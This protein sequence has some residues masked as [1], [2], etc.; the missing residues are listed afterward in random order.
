MEDIKKQYKEAIEYF[1][2]K[3][4]FIS[5]VILITILSFGF[6]ITNSSVGMDDVSFDRYY[7]D[8]EMLA[9]GRW[10]SY[11]VYQILN[12]TDFVPFWI[13]FIA[14]TIIMSVAVVW[15]IFLKKNLGDK[16][17]I[18]SYIIFASVFISFPIINEI[19]IYQNCN[20]AVMLGS[21]LASIGIMLLYENFNNIHKKRIY[22]YCMLILTLGI[23]MYEACA[24]IVLVSIIIT[25]FLIMYKN[26][27]NKN[28]NIFKY[29]LLA[30]GILTAS[31]VLNSIILKIIYLLGVDFSGVAEKQIGWGKIKLGESLK[32][33]IKNI[34]NGVTK[35]RY[36]PI[37]I[38]DISVIIGFLIGIIQTYKKQNFMIILL[39]IGM[40]LSNFAISIIQLNMVMY[41]TC[42]SWSLFVAIII[43][44]LYIYLKKYKITKIIVSV[45]ITILILQQTKYM[46]QYFYNDYIRYEKDLHVAY[47][48]INRLKENYNIDKPLVITGTPEMS[49]GEY[50]NQSNGL[51]ILWWGRKAFEGMGI[52]YIKFLNTLGYNFKIPTSEQ[53]EKGN[54]RSETMSIYPKEGSII[55]LEDCIVINF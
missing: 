10:G 25:A 41:R 30:L 12:I 29:I 17:S 33:L 26:G 45:F 7:Q 5:I 35:F 14:S 46:N 34:Q 55:E 47:E 49:V 43:M 51:S 19:F 44:I 50:G 37:K 24:Q 22:V 3:K 16:L 39:Y 18:T 13:D 32:K 4:I 2:N 20:I 54:T 1:I 42:T 27:E 40:V 9:I 15:C 28:K 6:A 52:E 53:Y 8:K 23:S 36:F 38:F 21:L 31:V 11:L 48:L